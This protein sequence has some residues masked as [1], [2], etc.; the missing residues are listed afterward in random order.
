MNMLNSPE[1]CSVREF[2]C[3]GKQFSAIKGHFPLKNN[4]TAL[5]G[6]GVCTENGLNG[7]PDNADVEPETP[8]LHVPDVAFHTTLHLPKFA[9]LAT[10]TCYLGVC[11]IGAAVLRPRQQV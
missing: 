8:V 4:V 10:E 9:G 11:N 5:I 6:I 1:N 3:K 2:D 7:H